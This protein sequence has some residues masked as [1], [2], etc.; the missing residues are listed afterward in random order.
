MGQDSRSPLPSP[1]STHTGSPVST[2]ASTSPEGNTVTTEGRHHPVAH[3]TS[4]GSQSC[5]PSGYLVPV[6]KPSADE[7]VYAFVPNSSDRVIP[8]HP[9]PPEVVKTTGCTNAAYVPVDDR[10]SSRTGYP[11]IRPPT[12]VI[13]HG[14]G[15]HSPLERAEYPHKLAE[16][17]PTNVTW[18]N[19]QSTAVREKQDYQPKALHVV[20]T[21]NLRRENPHS[22]PGNLHSGQHREPNMVT[23]PRH[24]PSPVVTMVNG[25]SS[26]QNPA[27]LNDT[28]VTNG[29]GIRSSPH[30]NPGV[31][32]INNPTAIYVRPRLVPREIVVPYHAGSGNVPIVEYIKTD[33]ICDKDL[34]YWTAQNVAEFIS[35][36]DCSDS[37]KI[38]IEEVRTYIVLSTSVH[39]F[40]LYY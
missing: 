2:M 23:K 19:V 22:P 36:T 32:T 15:V 26:V 37:A 6:Y 8:G 10:Y 7:V 20:P 28:A 3:A 27:H 40:I 24:S 13:H 9:R 33:V 11:A 31:D 30:G 12:A 16:P 5:P 38:F 14:R 34:V 17:Q 29:P 39:K 4:T 35:A 25:Y 1:S 18:V 21:T